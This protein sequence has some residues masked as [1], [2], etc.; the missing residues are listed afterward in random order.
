MLSLLDQ[1]PIRPITGGFS[2][3]FLS[4]KR[5][6]FGGVPLRPGPGGVVPLDTRAGIAVVVPGRTARVISPRADGPTPNVVAWS[7]D[8][9][10]AV[11]L[12]T[13]KPLF[14]TTK[15]RHALI[16]ATTGTS[17]PLDLPTYYRVVDRSPDGTCY[18]AVR[19]RESFSLSKGWTSST[20]L[21]A[22]YPQAELS[23]RAIELAKT[24]AGKAPLA[25]GSAKRCLLENL[26]QD[27][28]GAAATEAAHFAE[29]F[30]TSDAREG[31]AAFLEKRAACFA[32]R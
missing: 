10:R 19:H 23:S 8:G 25:L 17:K 31:F 12:T 22:V 11:G 32:G 9:T 1:R 21:D 30:A 15:Y 18:L 29:L 26:Y 7:P 20:A 13:E 27:F 2:T 16:D 5:S 28:D 24:L 6:S 4:G 3:G 14:G